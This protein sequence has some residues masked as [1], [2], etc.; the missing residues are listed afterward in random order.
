MT[1]YLFAPPAK[2][3]AHDDPH[4][5]IS[6]APSASA[7][8]AGESFSVV[9]SFR[10]TREPVSYAQQSAE[11]VG[12][13]GLHAEGPNGDELPGRLRKIGRKV[14]AEAGPSRPTPLK[15]ASPALLGSP[16]SPGANP[17]YRA[18]GWPKHDESPIRSPD[19]WDPGSA[20]HVRRARS[21]ALGKGGMSPQELVWALAERR[22][23]TERQS[24]R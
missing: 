4:L 15:L 14:N 9:I 3:I 23:L 6:V 12:G 5:E 17:L 22:F 11:D 13:N 10:N 2:A 18:P 1:S 21:M 8:Y 19:G 24:S 20:G 16:Y 7:F